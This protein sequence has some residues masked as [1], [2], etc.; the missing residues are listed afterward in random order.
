MMRLAIDAFVVAGEMFSIGIGEYSD[1]EIP[2]SIHGP[3]KYGDGKTEWRQRKN[4]EV[5]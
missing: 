1:M 4:T 5:Y 3:W 2:G